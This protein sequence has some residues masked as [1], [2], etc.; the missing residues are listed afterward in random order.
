MNPYLQ[1]LLARY[2]QQLA[3]P[4]RAPEPAH[5]YFRQ[6]GS[7]A[8]QPEGYGALGPTQER[9]MAQQPQGYGALGPLPQGGTSNDPL[10]MLL[11]YLGMG[12]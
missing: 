12:R 3:A 4:W 5:Q 1:A 6:P 9:L 2:G 7:V 10:M 8:P 11:R